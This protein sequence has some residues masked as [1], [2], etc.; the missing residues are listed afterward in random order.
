MMLIMI[1]ITTLMKNDDDDNND[2]HSNGDGVSLGLLPRVA[3]SSSSAAL[4]C[5]VSF[6]S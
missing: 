2:N 5:T 6:Y 3:I 1:T 4:S